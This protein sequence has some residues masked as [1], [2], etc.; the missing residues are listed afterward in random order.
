MSRSLTMSGPLAPRLRASA[1]AS[2]SQPADEFRGEAGGAAGRAA[3]ARA[4][5]RHSACQAPSGRSS[6]AS[7]EPVQRRAERGRAQR[8]GADEDG[9]RRVLLLRHRRG[10]PAARPRRA[11]RSRCG[12]SVA[13]SAAIM[14][15]RV[16]G[17]HERVAELGDRPAVRVPGRLGRGEP[18]LRGEGRGQSAATLPAADAR[19]TTRA[20]RRRRPAAA[21]SAPR[22]SASRPVR[23]EHAAQPVRRRAARPWSARRAG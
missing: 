15:T 20:C 6:T 4:A 7:A 14:P 1:A 11:R 5:A 13:T 2:T 16:D 23:A 22:A 18:E 19:R 10:S 17:L 8:G 21:G 3:A 12:T 9:C